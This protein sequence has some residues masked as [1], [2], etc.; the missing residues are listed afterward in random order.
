MYQSQDMDEGTTCYLA[1]AA[2]WSGIFFLTANSISN[3]YIIITSSQLAMHWFST[4]CLKL[5]TTDK[6]VFY[7][8]NE[9]ELAIPYYYTLQC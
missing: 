1:L 5:T 2:H 4:K 7:T 9:Y 6:L 8:F 3:P